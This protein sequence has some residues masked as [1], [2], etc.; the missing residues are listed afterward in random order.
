[1]LKKIDWNKKILNLI[2]IYGFIPIVIALTFNVLVFTGT[3]PLTKYLPHHDIYSKLDQMIP[4]CP[5]WMVIY[6]LAFPT[7]AIGYIMIAREERKICYNM[8]TA[9]IIAKAL[10]LLCFFV[11]P[12]IMIDPQH[13]EPF[14]S[15][16]QD[17]FIGWL[18][19][20]VYS[21]DEPNNLFP[22]IHCLESWFV[23]RAAFNLKHGGV[24]YKTFMFVAAMLVF[25]SVLF[26]KQHVIIDVIGGVAVVEIALFFAKKYNLGRVFSALERK[27]TGKK[28][29]E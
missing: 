11:Y 21:F 24:K 25:A 13:A 7:W 26:V 29:E 20:F 19:R 1:M 5:W 6:V 12:T 17:G 15:Q 28:Q 2:P 10:V 8:F 22:S 3:R 27:I 9:E 14:R 4:F 23:F 18:C 16:I